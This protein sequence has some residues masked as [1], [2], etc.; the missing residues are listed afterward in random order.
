MLVLNSAPMFGLRTMYLLPFD[1]MKL[2]LLM[3]SEL[4]LL[5][6]ATQM[7]FCRSHVLL[8][9]PDLLTTKVALSRF[10]A[11]LVISVFG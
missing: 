6:L 7:N 8:L 11:R 4:L 3:Y 10:A 1:P 9:V 5:L 2:S